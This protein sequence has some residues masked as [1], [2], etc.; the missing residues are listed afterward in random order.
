MQLSYL[1]SYRSNTWT[2]IPNILKLVVLL[3]DNIFFIRVTFDRSLIY[4]LFLFTKILHA[5]VL[6]SFSCI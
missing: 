3:T 1:R 6:S 2:E 4:Y 5:C